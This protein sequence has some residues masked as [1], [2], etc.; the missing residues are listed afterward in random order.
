MPLAKLVA[1]CQ[2]HAPRCC[3]KGMKLWDGPG[4]GAR[5]PWRVLGGIEVM[6]DNLKAVAQAGQRVLTKRS[7]AERE[8]CKAR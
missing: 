7:E 5:L 1:N 2:L 6:V 3:A 8:A 4:L